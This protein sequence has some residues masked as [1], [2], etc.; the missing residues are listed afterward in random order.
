MEHP[1]NDVKLPGYLH[2]KKKAENDPSNDRRTRRHFGRRY[3]T[4]QFIYQPV[5]QE[6]DRAPENPPDALLRDRVDVPLEIAFPEGLKIDD[7]KKQK[8]V[9][10]KQKEITQKIVQTG[11][12]RRPLDVVQIDNHAEHEDRAK[13]R[14]KTIWNGEPAAGPAIRAGRADRDD[15]RDSPPEIESASNDREHDRPHA[16]QQAGDLCIK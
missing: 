8:V 5:K 15:G 4:F 14:P 9:I 11:R 3:H 2:V 6:L 12:L 1:D 16:D 10:G 13:D 7:G